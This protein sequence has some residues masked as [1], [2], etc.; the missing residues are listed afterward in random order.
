MHQPH[1]QLDP[2]TLL[3]LQE[4]WVRIKG[5][6]PPAI[7]RRVAR[8][9]ETLDRASLPG[10]LSPVVTVLPGLI[11]LVTECADRPV[12]KFRPTVARLIREQQFI[13]AGD[14]IIDPHMNA[15][16]EWYVEL[17]ICVLNRV[18][19]ID[20]EPDIRHDTPVTPQMFG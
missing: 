5:T 7:S 15:Q 20:H 6:T 1:T 2:T 12:S 13:S 17:T 10:E 11:R 19:A 18:R 4:E 9:Q 8:E 14:A 3:L 16:M